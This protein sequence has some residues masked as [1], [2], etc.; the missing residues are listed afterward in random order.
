MNICNTDI[1]FSNYYHLQS[2]RFEYVDAY[3]DIYI[4]RKPISTLQVSR[5]NLHFTV[6]NLLSNRSQLEKGEDIRMY[7]K[8]NV[9]L[10]H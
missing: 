1:F 8:L 3:D 4:A 10:V 5:K 6:N 9:T 7:N 2:V